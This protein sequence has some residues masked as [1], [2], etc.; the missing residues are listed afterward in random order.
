MRAGVVSAVVALA[1]FAQ[2][3]TWVSD[4]HVDKA[5]F[6]STGRNDYFSLEPGRVL[7]LEHGTERLVITVLG[8]TK[9]ID[10]VETRVVEERETDKGQLVEVSLNYFAIS[11]KTNDV[12]Y[13][14]ETV[15]MYKNGKVNSHEGSWMA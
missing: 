8:T 15:D 1:G 9:V 13:F 14:G 4:F 2:G 11:R 10:G 3:N 5:D 6:A 12:Y 7:T